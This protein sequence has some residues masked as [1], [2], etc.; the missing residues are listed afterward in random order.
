MPQLSNAETV[1]DPLLAD[2]EDS[3]GRVAFLLGNEAIVRDAL[4]SGWPATESTSRCYHDGA[5]GRRDLSAAELVHQDGLHRAQHRIA[6]ALL[7]KL[8]D[9]R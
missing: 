4:A 8:V 1:G 7:L 6:D 2:S 5:H 9:Q 3:E